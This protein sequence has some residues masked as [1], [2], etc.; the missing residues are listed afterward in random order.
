[1]PGRSLKKS[2]HVKP[3]NYR[4]RDHTGLRDR[5]RLR[6]PLRLRRFKFLSAGKRHLNRH[7]SKANIQRKGRARFVSKP[8]E[9]KVKRMLPSHRKN[10]FKRR[11]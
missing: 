5:L 1:M 10:A 2:L 8:D 3:R 4:V 9:W 7:K 6:G 11:Q